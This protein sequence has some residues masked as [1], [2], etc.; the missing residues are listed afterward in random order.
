MARSRPSQSVGP[1]VDFN[2]VDAHA[3]SQ[4]VRGADVHS[5]SLGTKEIG[6]QGIG[7]GD[8]Q[9]RDRECARLEVQLRR[10]DV[11]CGAIGFLKGAPKPVGG[12]GTIQRQESRIDRGHQ[13]EGYAHPRNPNRGRFRAEEF[14]VPRSGDSSQKQS[15]QE[16]SGSILE[17][18]VEG[19]RVGLGPGE[20]GPD[21]RHGPAQAKPEQPTRQR[22]K[23]E[24]AGGHII[25]ETE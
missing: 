17:H 21:A 11:H 5:D 25:F 19:L 20:P 16:A 8:G 23:N 12:Q 13:G 18:G 1:A 22:A 9:A 6:A 15:D 3:L 10:T 14:G 24:P 4:K 7:V 2:L